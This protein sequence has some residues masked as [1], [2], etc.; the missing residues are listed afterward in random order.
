[1]IRFQHVSHHYPSA[2]GPARHVLTDLSFTVGRGEL[3]FL[4]GA[5]GSGKSTVMQLALG[6]TQPRAGSIHIGNADLASLKR[7]AL[8]TL[9]RSIGYIAQ[10]A[11]L[12]ADRNILANVALPAHAAGLPKRECLARAQVALERVGLDARAIGPLRPQ[13]LSGG[14]ARRAC[15][16][17]ALVGRPT[18]LLVDELTAYLDQTSAQGLIQLLGQFAASGVTV[19]AATHDEHLAFASGAR[20]IRLSSESLQ[21]PA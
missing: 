12:L 16:A 8:P 10:D 21:A 5:C 19:L 4:V 15:L 17:R 20:C 13:Q 7:S 2:H 14:Q 18:L 9:R 11:R 1:M 6:L 3:V